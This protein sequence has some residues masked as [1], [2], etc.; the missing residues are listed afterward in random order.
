[1]SGG[2]G[3]EVTVLAPDA[4]AQLAA[5]TGPLADR[6]AFRDMYRATAPDVYR[7]ARRRV[8]HH[9]AEDVTA[10][11][12]VRAW[13]SR[14]TFRDD[15]GSPVG[16]LIRIAQRV[17]IDRATRANRTPGPTAHG[18]PE[19]EVA[20]PDDD[21]H[22]E[23]VEQDLIARALM[24][25]PDRQREVLHRRFLRDQS[26]E[27]TA[28]AMGLSPEAVRALTYRSLRRL[29]TDWPLPDAA[30]GSNTTK[31]RP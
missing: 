31:D 10:E 14:H 11:T 13:R 22:G 25:L 29:R 18:N 19:G 30:T 21:G 9:E 28:S 1:M 5:A 2:A 20:D 4:L 16:W 24:Q 26:V 12:Y 15:G 3:S 6:A 8:D 23:V 17:M 27:Q 7:Y